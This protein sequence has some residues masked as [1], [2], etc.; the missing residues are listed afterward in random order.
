MLNPAPRLAVDHAT[1][2]ITSQSPI[3]TT[4]TN[5]AHSSYLFKPASLDATSATGTPTPSLGRVKIVFAESKNPG[6]YEAAEALAKTFESTLKEHLVWKDHGYYDEEDDVDREHPEAAGYGTTI[7]DTLTSYA[8]MFS[9]KLAE[10]TE[11]HVQNSAPIR[12]TE[13]GDSVKSLASST[14][15]FT[16]RVA[17]VTGAVASTIT[18]VVH[19]SAKYVG[20]V[21]HNTAQEIDQKYIG[22]GGKPGPIRQQV[23]ET[24]QGVKE[25]GQAAY[26]EAAIAGQGIKDA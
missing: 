11:S 19:D 2:P 24:A 3:S 7:A 9:N 13:P 16:N 21:A 15:G 5:K 23:N 1:F 6:A 4:D 17:E 12:P 25:M 14:E 20:E 22:G 10:L 8:R 26:N 18:T